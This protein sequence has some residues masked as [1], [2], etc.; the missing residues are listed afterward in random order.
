MTEVNLKAKAE[1]SVFVLVKLPAG[2]V[3]YAFFKKAWLM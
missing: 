1:M 2:N 3:L